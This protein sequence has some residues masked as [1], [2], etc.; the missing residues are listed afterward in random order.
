MVSFAL[1][2]Q[3]LMTYLMYAYTKEK[4]AD[5]PPLVKPTYILYSD[6]Y[7]RLLSV[8]GSI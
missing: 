1:T 2:Q 4:V 5:I 7:F 6:V 3:I 8:F